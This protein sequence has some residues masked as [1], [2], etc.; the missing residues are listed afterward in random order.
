M[1]ANTPYITLPEPSSLKPG[2]LCDPS[3][4]RIWPCEAIDRFIIGRMHG[5]YDLDQT[6]LHL[7]FVY[8]D[9]ANV[10]VLELEKFWNAVLSC[11]SQFHDWSSRSHE[12]LEVRQVLID[13]KKLL[14][15]VSEILET[16]YEDVQN[17]DVKVS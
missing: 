11:T 4:G 1:D 2:E 14:D 17:E 6:V 7:S 13:I 15:Q 8:R 10:T 9:L 16:E 12:D 5:D 3:T